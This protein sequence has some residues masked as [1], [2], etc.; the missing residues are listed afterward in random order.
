MQHPDNRLAIGSSR[1]WQTM[2]GGK[3][4]KRKQWKSHGTHTH[5]YIQACTS[6]DKCISLQSEFYIFS[7][8]LTQKNRHVQLAC[9]DADYPKGFPSF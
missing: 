5:T 2:C 3:K 4:I 8:V 7:V 6:T 9:V 1:Q